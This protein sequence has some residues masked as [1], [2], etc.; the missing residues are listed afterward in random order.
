MLQTGRL[1]T[2]AARLVVLVLVGVMLAC[3]LL[4]AMLQPAEPPYWALSHWRSF[5][6]LPAGFWVS[7]LVGLGAWLVSAWVF[8]LRPDDSAIRLFA[9][10]GVMTLAFTFAGTFSAL[11]MPVSAWVQHLS[12][13]INVAGAS[14]FGIAIICLFATYPEPLP[15]ARAIV[16]AVVLGFGGWTLAV[17]L[18]PADGFGAVQAIT[19]FEMLGIMALA[20]AQAL[21][22][23]RDPGKRAIA[24]WLGL[25]VL[26][27]AGPFIG[28]VATPLTF[29][30][31]SLVDE[32]LAFSSF[33]LFYI[34][35][36]IGLMR[37][38]LFDL[39]TW[40]YGLL[41]YAL[42]GAGLMLIDLALM[43]VLAFSP[44]AAFATTLGLVAVT[45]LPL[46]DFIW[47][48]I[49]RRRRVDEAAVFAQVV[50]SVLR[51]TPE[52][53]VSAWRALATEMFQPLEV[54]EGDPALAAPRL[55]DDG[56]LLELPAVL[57]ASALVLR[58]KQR[59]AALFTRRD[60]ELAQQL[61]QLA[62]YVEANRSAYD[63]GVNQERLRIARDI[64]DNIG[65]QLMQALHSDEAPRK[66]AM[67]RNTLA[68][69]REIINNSQGAELPL[70]ALLADLRAEA[71][72]R[73]EPHGITL[74]WTAE[75]PD[76][77]TLSKPE[78]HS[79][80][81]AIREATSNVIK[82]AG[83]ARMVVAIT[84]DGGAIGLTI[85]DDGRGLTESAAGGGGHGLANMR[86]RFVSM[87]GE[88]A[89]GAAEATGGG[90]TTITA[91]LPLG[92][93]TIPPPRGRPRA[94]GE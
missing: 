39:G 88:F 83:A 7:W 60:A 63:Q 47:S 41:F 32:N 40:A 52:D 19:F 93:S 18:G 53:R 58:Y 15:G 59:G 20:V 74:D 3:A 75:V 73:L 14:G 70:E 56:K 65:A 69:L 54:S 81:S 27:G 1:T 9:L 84:L 55:S 28:L 57:G 8:A 5:A 25:S 34:G 87:G 92:R 10:S 77:L 89:I 44:T 72:E 71:G 50:Q 43:S 17:L 11:A 67:I 94:V 76:G 49:G 79:L 48:R 51:P 46:R 24:V 21:R 29:G 13:L 31:D 33:L 64:H 35:I 37:Y 4:V 23:W 16:A 85:A 36:A 30:F 45:W 26:I 90:G 12:G 2:P 78:V 42:A 6:D 91:T 61:V 80:R 22:P 62:D 68:D 86:T 38:R 82:H 66:D